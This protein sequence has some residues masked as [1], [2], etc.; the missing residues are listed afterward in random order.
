VGPGT[1]GDDEV[2]RESHQLRNAFLTMNG[3]FAG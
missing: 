1:I 3:I 2:L